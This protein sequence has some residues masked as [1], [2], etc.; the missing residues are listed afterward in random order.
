MHRRLLILIASLATCFGLAV[1]VA[2]AGPS[3]AA[4][5]DRDCGDFNTQAAAQT[6]YINHGGPQSDPHGLDDDSDG[7]ACESNPCPCSHN[8]GGGDNA[9]DEG[10][11]GPRNQWAKIV[12]VWTGDT[13]RVRF[14]GGGRATVRMI[15]VN[16]PDVRPAQCG[17][18]GARKA[19][20]RL[21]PRGAR[22][23]LVVDSKQPNKDTDGNLRRYVI[24]GGRDVNFRQ[25]SNGW[26]R[27]TSGK[28]KRSA[29]YH[30]AER[31]ASS[32]ERGLWGTC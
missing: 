10:D 21:L 20:R 9:P 6:F 32:N 16:S 18:F 13:A 3:S 11:N 15:G 17:A 22:V 19:A 31:V 7:V 5:V 23:K 26:G 25:L 29:G 4:V 27:V 28:Y 2:L 12:K 8:Q 1:P 14:S 24:R 30:R